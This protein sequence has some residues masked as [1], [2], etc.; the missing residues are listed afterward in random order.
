MIHVKRKRKSEND[1]SGISMGHV[2]D[3]RPM[4]SCS[5]YFGSTLLPSFAHSDYNYNLVVPLDLGSP[6]Y[7]CHFCGAVF[8]Y[9]ERVKAA[10]KANPTYTVCCGGGQVVLP[11]LKSTPPFLYHLLDYSH[12]GFCRAFRENIRIYNSM[13][14]FTSS[15]A[16]VDASINNG[17]GTYVYRINGQN[18][19][20]I[21]S[22]LPEPGRRP[23]FAQLYVFDTDNEIDNRVSLFGSSTDA[24]HIDKFIVSE[25][26]KFFDEY[27]EIAKAFRMIRDRFSADDV[28]P[29]RLRL[30]ESRVR[31]GIQYNLPSSSELAALILGD[32]GQH[33]CGRDII[34]EH[35]VSGLQRVSELHPSFMAMQYPILF[36]F[37]EDGYRI[38]LK[39]NIARCHLDSKRERITMR[40]YYAFRL[41][42][43]HGEGSTL[44]RGGRLLQQYIV[45][46][47]CSVEE[48]RLRY[49]VDNQKQFRVE[50]YKGIQDA[51]LRGDTNTND[52]G[53]RV[54]LPSSFTAGPRYMIQNYHDAI[55]ICKV[56][57]HPN[58]FI[59][60]TCNAQWP[61]IIDALKLIPGQRPEDRPDIVSRVF[62]M[63][64]NELMDDIKKK[65]IF[66]HA[67]A[68]IHTVEFQKRGLPHVHILVWL[69]LSHQNPSALD[70][71]LIISA[72]IPNKI[73]YPVAYETVSRFM[74][75]GPCGVDNHRSPC[76]INGKCSKHYPKE[77][78]PNTVIGEN[79]APV[80]RRRDDKSCIIKNHVPLDNK[81]VV[82][83]N[84]NLIVKYQAHI[85]VEWCNRSRSIKY[86]FK[87]INKGP[88]RARAVI[89]RGLQPITAV[90][91]QQ[92]TS[93]PVDEVKLYLD[94]RYLSAYEAVWRLFEFKIHYRYP[95]VERL[96]IH[97]PGMNSVLLGND[98][99]L[100]EIGYEDSISRTMFTQWMTTNSNNVDARELTYVLF[101]TQWVWNQNKRTWTK[102]KRG[103][104][105]G[106]IVYVHPSLGE[107]YYL[108]ILLNVV[109]GPCNY[110]DI[111]T[112]NNVLYPSFKE[113][114]AAHGFLGDDKE[115]EEALREAECWA[116]ATQLRQLF[117]TIVVFCEVVNPSIL[118]EKFIE[119]LSDDLVY[120]AND[121][122]HL[123]ALETTTLSIKN[124][125]LLQLETLFNANSTSL[126]DHRLP[127]PTSSSSRGFDNRFVR[128]EMSYD[129]GH[130]TNVHSDMV[131]HLNGDQKKVYDSV[132]ESVDGN[133]GRLFFVYGHGGTG[134]TFLYQTIITKIRSE[135]KIVL[136]VASSG[137]ASLLLPGGRTA[138][139][140]FKIPIQISEHSTCDIKKGT[141]L[142]RLI[143]ESSLIVWD[144]APMVHRYCFEALDRT[145]RDILCDNDGRDSER[146]FGGK[147]ILLGGDFR[148]I[149]PVVAKGTRSDTVNACISRSYLWKH[150]DIHLLTINMRLSLTGLD[151]STQQLMKDFSSWILGIGN[152]TIE[153]SSSKAS[154]DDEMWINLPQHL[155]LESLDNHI[156]CISD[157]IYGDLQIKYSDIQYLKERAIVTPTNDTVDAINE[158]LLLR[159]PTKEIVYYSFD[160]ICRSSGAIHDDDLLYPT[161]FLNSI[162]FNGLPDH[163]LK[164]RVNTPIMLL[165]NLNQTS[166]LCNGTRLLVNRLGGR[167]IEATIIGGTNEN[168]RVYIPRIVMSASDGKWPFTLK[169]RQ[170]PVRLCYAMTINKSQGQ[171]LKEM[172]LYLPA[173]VFSHGQLYVALSRVTSFEGLKILLGKDNHAS[174]RET[175]N[176]VYS[177]IFDDL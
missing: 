128:E 113:A 158:H 54:I 112:V 129:Y 86:L 109:K 159:V 136:A 91:G 84:V 120:K 107:L 105:I 3:G 98:Q 103:M 124:Q 26:V 116:S 97:L 57:G 12:L 72:E 18:H 19:H 122:H 2:G 92:I 147:T 145:M 56:Y 68:C 108:R 49:V 162:K 52:V 80:Y 88:D 5:G 37:G 42:Y 65:K 171:T 102:R 117:M 156:H 169:R 100:R 94:C 21:G 7:S 173:P 58:L 79:N 153:C 74:M 142:A 36:P 137:I 6:I 46:A 157:A 59:T 130:L 77:F 166:G 78:V 40:E 168:S 154:R 13:F 62:K 16:R 55:A 14:A 146:L 139:S 175:R 43:R 34:V 123:G 161:E 47:F 106:R 110:E 135:A 149:L 160:S 75:H 28:I 172:G 165:R 177:E 15:G 25:L 39:R 63:K 144:E 134:K 51:L 31:D 89:E 8:W 48:V 22:L 35:R 164:L 140:R 96:A 41:Q 138:H 155:L 152:G 118:L 38:D 170:F 4:G 32:F 70:I 69:S 133:L 143:Q 151:P 148:Q 150:C 61:E 126:S 23:S 45:D 83:H 60:F 81:H 85:N 176:V 111:R 131:H 1:I 95:A 10:P 76:M 73:I 141:Q 163:E 132:I 11:F 9:E 27:N 53:K 93:A 99:D 71:D 82:P 121:F 44:L 167:V 90:G 101:P 115:W 20:R 30:L 104:S 17:S 50:M 33:S 119:S 29:L 87:Y 114:C 125:L 174:E 64:V 24:R 66:G 127:L 67:V